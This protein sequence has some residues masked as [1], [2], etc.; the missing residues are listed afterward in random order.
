MPHA[1]SRAGAVQDSANDG[2]FT[3]VWGTD[4]N[5]TDV[6]NQF[7][8]FVKGF[9]EH[10]GT[11]EDGVPV[12]QAEAKYISY[13]K[14]VRSACCCRRLLLDCFCPCQ[15][16]GLPCVRKLLRTYVRALALLVSM[17][18]AKFGLMKMCAWY[19]DVSKC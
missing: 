7:T 3:M 9:R 8:Q 1:F 6:Q 17:L 2:T 15:T 14:D 19:S 4:I 10:T 18:W 13:L 16:D 12:L 11:D 5:V